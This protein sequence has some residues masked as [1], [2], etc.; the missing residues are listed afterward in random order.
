MDF[1]IWIYLI[2]FLEKIFE[3]LI[4]SFR[5]IIYAA[6]FRHLP[7]LLTLISSLM[8]VFVVSIVL[9]GITDDPLK[10]FVYALGQAFGVYAGGFVEEKLALGNSLLYVVIEDKYAKVISDSLRANG[11]GA[12]L[13]NATGY[14]SKDRKMLIILCRRKDNYKV[15]KIVKKIDEN[16][17]IMVKKPTQVTGSYVLG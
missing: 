16:F 5:Q 14:E 1:G 7:A 6:G 2:I 10:L 8:W 11:F 17:I 12:T 15:Q 4:T 13:V 3:N 9:I